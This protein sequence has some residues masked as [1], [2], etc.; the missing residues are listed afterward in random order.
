MRGGCRVGRAGRQADDPHLPLHPLKITT[1]TGG[2]SNALY[3]ATP[4]VDGDLGPVLCRVYGLNTDNFIERK[5]E[6][7][8]MQIVNKH[9]FG[10]EVR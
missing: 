6:V 9:G 5:K 2:I 7:A 10:T 8:I 3:K 1:I 4:T